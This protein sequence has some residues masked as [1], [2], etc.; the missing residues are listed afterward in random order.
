MGSVTIRVAAPRVEFGLLGALEVRVGGR[1]ATIGSRPQRLALPELLPRGGETGGSG[2]RGGQRQG[3]RR[4]GGQTPAAN[5][6]EGPAGPRVPAA[7]RAGGA[8]DDRR[9]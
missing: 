4:L 8:R 2:R 9:A 5:S 3:L 1:Q 6:G 7:A